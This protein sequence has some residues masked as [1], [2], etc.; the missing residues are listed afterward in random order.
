MVGLGG[1]GGGLIVSETGIC[2]WLAF[3]VPVE[4]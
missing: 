2:P 4:A 3:W 1:L